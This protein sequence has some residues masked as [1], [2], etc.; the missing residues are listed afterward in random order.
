MNYNHNLSECFDLCNFYHNWHVNKSSICIV[1][2]VESDGALLFLPNSNFWQSY[3]Y[4]LKLLRVFGFW[5]M[6]VRV[7]DYQNRTNP[8][9]YDYISYVGTSI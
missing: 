4:P 3:K 8:K 9:R 1:S 2:A 7:M 5:A 6:D